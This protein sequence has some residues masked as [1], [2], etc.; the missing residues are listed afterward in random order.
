LVERLSDRT[1]HRFEEDNYDQLSTLEAA[2]DFLT[3]RG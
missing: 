3:Y 1:G 2:I